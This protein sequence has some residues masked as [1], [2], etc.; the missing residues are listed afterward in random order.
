MIIAAPS[1]FATERATCSSSCRPVGWIPI[2]SVPVSSRAASWP[3]RLG[4]RSSG[5]AWV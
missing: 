2:L 5:S 1:R 3:I 4:I